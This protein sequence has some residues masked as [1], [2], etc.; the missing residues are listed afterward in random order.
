M[1]AHGDVESLIS[2][3]AARGVQLWVADG[4]LRYRAPKGTLDPQHLEQIRGRRSELCAYILAHPEDRPREGLPAAPDHGAPLSLTQERLWFL[5]KLG[6]AES[7]YHIV[8]PLALDGILN[9]VALVRS[10]ES[11]LRRHGS[12]RTR[13]VDADGEGVQYVEEK[14]NVPLERLDLETVPEAEEVLRSALRETVER[15]FVLSEAPLLRILLVK[16][17]SHR[18]VLLIVVHHIVSDGWSVLSVLPRELAELYD[19]FVQGRAA[20]LPPLPLQYTDFARWQRERLNGE[21]LQAQLSYWRAQLQGLTALELP[22]DRPRPP[23]PSHAGATVHGALPEELTEALQE[24][25]RR[26]RLTPFMVLLASL[27]WVLG[28]WAGQD[29]VAVGAAI[30]GRTHPDSEGLIGF[31]VNTLVLRTNLAG[32]P[33]VRA[34]LERVRRMTLEAYA[35]QD[36]PFEKL[37]AELQP[38][39]D[40]S[41]QPLFQVLVAMHNVPRQQFSLSDVQ[42]SWLPHPTIRAK[43]DLNLHLLE[44]KLNG[45][46]GFKLY[47]DYATELFDAVTVQRLLERWRR[48]VEFMLRTPDSALDETQLMSPLERERILQAS[49][50]PETAEITDTT[51]HELFSRQAQETPDAIAIV[52]KS[53]QVTYR[54]LDRRSTNL[55]RFLRKRGIGNEAVV[56]V[57]VP[58]SAKL[59]VCILG[60]LKAGGAWLALDP[61]YPRRRLQY[62]VEDAGA[63]LILAHSTTSDLVVGCGVETACIDDEVGIGTD[64]EESIESPATAAADGLAYI[65]YTSGS[66][67]R[68]KGVMGVHRCAVN[69]FR[70]IQDTY[71][72]SCTDVVLQLTSVSFDASVRDLVGPLLWG[73]RICLLADSELNDFESVHEL[74]AEQ[75]VNTLLSITPTLLRHLAEGR[76]THPGVC[77]VCISGE[78]LQGADLR[79][80]R[81]M[82]GPGT[83]FVNQYGPAEA[84]MTCCFREVRCGDDAERSDSRVPIGRPLANVQMYVLD[85]G[86]TVVPTGVAGELWVGGSGV[87]RGY[88]GRPALTAERF[89]PDPW[90]AGQRLY[91][92]GDLARYRSDGELEFLGRHDQ[93]VKLRGN[94]VELGEIEAVLLGLNG[95]R[96]AAVAVR[97]Q[98]PGEQLLVA[99]VCCRNSVTA[100]AAELRSQL[101][102]H[103]PQYMIPSAFSFLHELPMLPNGKVDR[104]ALP[105]VELRTRAFVEPRTVTEQAIAALWA[106]LLQVER[107]GLHGNFFELGGHSLLAMRMVARA[108]AE[109]GWRVPLKGVFEAP[110]VEALARLVDQDAA[111]GP[112]AGSEEPLVRRGTA[113]PL[114][115]S[116]GQSLFESTYRTMAHCEF[117]HSW[118]VVQL[119]GSLDQRALHQAFLQITERHAALRM[120]YIRDA[121]GRATL[122]V[123][124]S[125]QLEFAVVESGVDPDASTIDAVV[126]RFDLSTGPL[127]RV[128]VTRVAADRHILAVVVHHSVCDAWSLGVLGRELS[129]FYTERVSGV[130]ARLRPLPI[131]LTDYTAWLREWLESDSGRRSLEYWRRLMSGAERPFELPVDENPATSVGS[132]TYVI[133][134]SISSAVVHALRAVALEAG[135]MLSTLLLSAFVAVLSKWSGRSDVFVDVNHPGRLR[136]ETH[137]LI[138]FLAEIWVLR[139][140]VSEGCG[141][142]D[143]LKEVGRLVRESSDHTQVPFWMILQELQKLPRTQP[144]LMTTFNYINRDFVGGKMVSSDPKLG[145]DVRMEYVER[146]LEAS[147]FLT[148]DTYKKLSVAI[149]EARDSIS[150]SIEYA[151]HRFSEATVQAFSMRLAQLLER[152]ADA[153]CGATVP[154]RR[155]GGLLEP[156][157]FGNAASLE[158]MRL[159]DTGS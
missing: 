35:H 28:S 36:V 10:F 9:E 20:Q 142:A 117:L 153:G 159:P 12:L 90:S 114:P 66:T 155:R 95:V 103:L 89:V 72:L 60:I 135:Q 5:S 139:T 122:E 133:G 44:E 73:A 102:E 116:F 16:L 127:L 106:E 104:R 150:W 138:G 51:L 50:G 55:A 149:L 154:L 27:Q 82:F 132:R 92:T 6:I 129:A 17:A 145:P 63:R 41:R 148:E 98:S 85:S 78:Q 14:V 83:V 143:L 23:T 84:T 81:G 87:T 96:E 38:P 113:G 52:C 147:R 100:S 115:M 56:A 19:A 77:R 112:H 128:R 26:E 146:P 48:A 140:N 30:A 24:F 29:D 46:R 31:F 15:P 39:R 134:G 144:L 110:T 137:D 49:R 45:G 75:R 62:M 58:R 124:D 121:A 156:W 53:E 69:Y 11:L 93:Q 126:R 119:L 37:V 131:D 101:A 111:R 1:T 68:P 152:V 3:L 109:F 34:L 47:C 22:T 21:T 76:W 67:G 157:D 107:V 70:R 33:T 79:A 54:D 8:L 32:A 125:P 61:N 57:C 120:R 130:P 74:I 97:G 136:P 91:R 94:R 80:G 141:F 99:Y 18:H 65:I 40:R 7:S 86:L 43:Y 13:I 105:E 118:F 88:V 64:T 59:L 108:R 158:S 42:V 25:S 4:R 123:V 2:S 151:G 71:G